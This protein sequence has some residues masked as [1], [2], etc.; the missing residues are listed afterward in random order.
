MRA[1]CQVLARR[2]GSDLT[3]GRMPSNLKGYGEFLSLSLEAAPC[4]LDK[5]PSPCP[6][7]TVWALLAGRGFTLVRGL[8]A[9]GS[10]VQADIGGH[11]V[12][13]VVCS[14]VPCLQATT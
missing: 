3:P 10:R 14:A 6:R 5:L 11:P 7:L 9:Q 8:L 4:L 13:F 1:V 2:A 12:S